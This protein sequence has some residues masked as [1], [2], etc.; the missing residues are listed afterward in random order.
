MNI[1]AN[2]ET[3]ELRVIS[4][5]MCEK[6]E[7]ALGYSL[8]KKGNVRPA[9]MNSFFANRIKLAQL[10]AAKNGHDL[11][12][13]SG[14][15]SLEYQQKLYS[16]AL[17]KNGSVIEAQKWVLPAV[18]SMHPWGLAVD[19]NYG[20]GKKEGAAWLEAN[21]F[22]FGLCRRYENEW[23]HFEPLVKPGIKCPALEPYAIA[24]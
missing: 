5:S 22:K 19:I 3:G 20:V 24:K 17:I 7:L 4:I 10:M 2:K 6:E 13:T 8:L 14:W 23:W 16:R 21:G 18:Y 9:Q 1:C 15:R 11:Q 12:I